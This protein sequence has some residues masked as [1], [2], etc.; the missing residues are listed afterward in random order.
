MRLIRYNE[1]ECVEY[2]WLNLESLYLKLHINYNVL[3]ANINIKIQSN[4]LKSLCLFTNYG[5]ASQMTID[6]IYQLQSLYLSNRLF[7]I[8]KL[9]MSNFTCLTQLWLFGGYSEIIPH[10]LEIAVGQ[11]PC[12]KTVSNANEP[13]NCTVCNVRK[14]YT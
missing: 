6:G 12:L 3:S 10:G 8:D 14:S 7:L 9:N 11:I 5:G 1:R 4:K 13:A 2:P